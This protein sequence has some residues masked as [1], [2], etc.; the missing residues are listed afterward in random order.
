MI[1]QELKRVNQDLFEENKRLKQ[2]SEV[3]KTS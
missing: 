1:S 3:A 2:N